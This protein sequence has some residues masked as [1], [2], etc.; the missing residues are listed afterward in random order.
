[1]RGRE[2][3]VRPRP[4]LLHTGKARETTGTPI[5]QAQRAEMSHTIASYLLRVLDGLEKINGP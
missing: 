5:Q 1:M 4:S 2:T 3:K